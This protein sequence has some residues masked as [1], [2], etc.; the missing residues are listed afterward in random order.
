[1][2]FPNETYLQFFRNTATW[3]AQEFEHLYAQLAG[4]LSREHKDDGSHAS[5]TADDV[6]ADYLVLRAARSD[7][8]LTMRAAYD[9]DVAGVRIATVTDAATRTGEVAYV[10][11]GNVNAPGPTTPAGPGLRF[12]DIYGDVWSTVVG[13][14]SL[15]D[16]YGVFNTQVTDGGAV[17]LYRV[18]D[19]LHW[20]PSGNRALTAVE[21]GYPGTQTRWDALHIDRATIYEG[22]ATTALG[23]WTNVAHAGGNFS[24]DTGTWTVASGDQA[25]FAY[26]RV[27][28]TVTVMVT[29]ETTTIAANPNELR[30][31]LPFTSTKTVGGTYWLYNNATSEAGLWRVNASSNV[32]RLYTAT[33]AA[34][35]NETDLTG[36][37][38]TVTMPVAS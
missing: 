14:D 35:T 38:V 27:G 33:A 20:A 23:D 32:L 26:T 2:P 3:I 4:Y 31:T 19:A 34:F 16:F 30:I 21:L 25:T 29:L 17:K 9:A 36:L 22:G 24:Q 8:G 37:F 1:M 11:I 15:N 13:V 18:G 28:L 5:V 12:H 6:T 7:T 10:D